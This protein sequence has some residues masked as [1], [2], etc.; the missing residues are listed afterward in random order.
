[1]RLYSCLCKQ[2]GRTNY[3]ISPL[4]LGHEIERFNA[5]ASTHLNCLVHKI[6]YILT[7]LWSLFTTVKTHSKTILYSTF[8]LPGI[9]ILIIDAQENY[10]VFSW[11]LV[12]YKL[13]QLHIRKFRSAC[14]FFFGLHFRCMWF[15]F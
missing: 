13:I 14:F 1:M 9:Q 3:P 5:P 8:D 7:L 11:V 2:D 4:L 12:T 15:E 6:I 10:F